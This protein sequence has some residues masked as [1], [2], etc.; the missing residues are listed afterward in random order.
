MFGS[1][2]ISFGSAPV[3]RNRNLLTSPLTLASSPTFPGVSNDMMSHQEWFS[4]LEKTMQPGVVATGD[5]TPHPIA[6]VGEVPLSHIEQKGKLMN[7]LH[8][9][10]ITKN[11][12]SVGQIVDKGMVVLFTHLRCFIEE[13]GRVIA[14]GRREGGCSSSTLLM[15]TPQCSRKDKKSSRTSTYGTSG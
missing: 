4:Y 2:G 12:V 11:M 5:I 13:E 7:V 6:N 3:S 10:T 1:V 15:V 9:P 8:I 14:Q